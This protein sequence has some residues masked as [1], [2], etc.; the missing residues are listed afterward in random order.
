MIR[1]ARLFRVPIESLHSMT[2]VHIRERRASMLSARHCE[3][4]RIQGIMEDIEI[5]RTS[6]PKADSALRY[7]FERATVAPH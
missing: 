6:N 5:E 1:S 2:F 4:T 7:A 3:K